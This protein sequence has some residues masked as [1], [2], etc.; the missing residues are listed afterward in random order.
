[1]SN[2]VQGLTYWILENNLKIFVTSTPVFHTEESGTLP[3]IL[4]IFG[5]LG[6]T[7]KGSKPGPYPKRRRSEIGALVLLLIHDFCYIC[8]IIWKMFCKL[9]CM[10]RF[11][12]SDLAYHAVYENACT[13]AE[14]VKNFS[15]LVHSFSYKAW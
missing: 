10:V 5:T 11:G 1:M 15:A 2:K 13:R 7:R 8:N 3:F 9:I 6:S 4:D 14:E 12:Q